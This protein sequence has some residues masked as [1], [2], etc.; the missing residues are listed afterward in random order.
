MKN[1]KE[2]GCTIEKSVAVATCTEINNILAK[3]NLNTKQF[4]EIFSMMILEVALN[5]NAPVDEF[6]EAMDMLVNDVKGCYKFA[7]ESYKKGDKSCLIH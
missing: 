4:I 5:A 6:N 7:L 3:N 2:Q 1:K